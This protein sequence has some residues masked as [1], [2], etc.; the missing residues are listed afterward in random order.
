MKKTGFTDASTARKYVNI[1]GLTLNSTDITEVLTR[2]EDFI[3]DSVKFYLVTPNPEL[4]LMAQKDEKLKNALNSA[5]LAIPDGIGLKIADRKLN[6]IK[7]RVL[8]LELIKLADKKKWKV[9]LLGGL[10]DEAEKTVDSLSQSLKKVKFNYA[11]GPKLNS[12]TEPATEV[13][14]KLQI[15]IFNQINAFKPQLLFVAFGNPKQEIWIH[16]NFS[17][18]DVGGAMAV[19]GAFRYIAGLS[20]LPPV[21]MG[22]A[23]LEW[24]WRVLREPGRIKRIIKAVVIFPLKVL[25]SKLWQKRA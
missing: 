7:G 2:V 10:N 15:D 20:K 25:C 17:M 22:K 8:F 24:L 5:D 1:L 11:K 23:G 18:L 16:K 4:I 12:D 19:G 14:R 3:S 13:D 21:W 9:F 6:I